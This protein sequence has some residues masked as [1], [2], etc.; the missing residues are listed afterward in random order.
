M[1]QLSLRAMAAVTIRAGRRTGL[2]ALRAPASGD[3]LASSRAAAAAQQLECVQRKVYGIP[4]STA[5]TYEESW[6]TR[7]AVLQE[8]LEV[9]K[10]PP[11]PKEEDLRFQI[12]HLSKRDPSEF[13]LWGPEPRSP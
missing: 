12:R 13:S 10:G 1:S 5:T 4:F 8:R 3:R 11:A 7:E 9:F 2:R 6:H